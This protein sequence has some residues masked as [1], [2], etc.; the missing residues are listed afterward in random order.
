MVI[1]DIFFKPVFLFCNF[2][3]LEMQSL[4]GGTFSSHFV[5]HSSSSCHFVV[6]LSER[7]FPFAS[8]SSKDAQYFIMSGW[9]HHPLSAN[10]TH[11]YCMLSQ[12]T[13]CFIY[14]SPT[15]EPTILYAANTTA[16]NYLR[17][18]KSFFFWM[19]NMFVFYYYYYYYHHFAMATNVGVRSRI[20]CI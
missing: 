20:V 19:P 4:S 7:C 10:A 3:K 8:K 12:A 13:K 11:T 1:H 5:S 18:F 9:L 2:Y 15:T 6:D 16:A 17:H 14:I